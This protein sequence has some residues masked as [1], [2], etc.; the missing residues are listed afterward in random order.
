MLALV[1]KKMAT[2]WKAKAEEIAVA[3]ADC[4]TAHDDDD[5]FVVEGFAALEEAG[6]F[7]ALVPAE[8][9]GGGASVGEICE[10]L[11]I[12]GATC[13]ST[14]LAASMHSHIVAVAAWRWK[15]QGAPTDALL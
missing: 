9:G 8:L 15:N 11:R 13:G 1:E 7:S 3:I 2:D 12:I 10:A 5:S 14:A 4:A 6:F